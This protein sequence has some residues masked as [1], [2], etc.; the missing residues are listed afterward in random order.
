M[1]SFF[2][3][4]SSA[5]LSASVPTTPEQ[6]QS[7]QD[8]AVADAMRLL[9]FAAE[10]GKSVD[11]AASKAVI[12]AASKRMSATPQ[13]LTVDEEQA[14]LSAYATVAKATDPVTA[15]S[16]RQTSDYENRTNSRWFGSVKTLGVIVLLVVFVLQAYYTVLGT[17]FERLDEADKIEM[18]AWK[19]YVVAV[20]SNVQQTPIDD[21]AGVVPKA[22]EVPSTQRR[23]AVD[24]FL[25]IWMRIDDA[26]TQLPGVLLG[27]E[28]VLRLHQGGP[29]PC[30]EIQPST[31]S[32]AASG[33]FQ[34]NIAHLKAVHTT[35]SLSVK[36]ASLDARSVLD[37]LAR[38]VLPVL[39]G[40]LGSLIYTLRSIAQGIEERTLTRASQA[41]NS[42]RIILGPILGLCALL[43]LSSDSS[44][45]AQGANPLSK[46]PAQ[47][48]ALVAGGEWH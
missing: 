39:M 29:E 34:P 17:R 44:G 23:D 30:A 37:V 28:S 13:P 14:F 20:N 36:R 19:E 22:G 43:L 46:L 40:L 25:P 9:A 3:R 33:G 48:I 4:W 2:R 38:Y 24:R 18:A 35:C 21:A 7:Q 8:A 12:Q 1:L 11:V 42:V 32:T 27:I 47:A 16:L 10:R 5:P 31:P 15:D 45:A 41:A 6:L 26:Q